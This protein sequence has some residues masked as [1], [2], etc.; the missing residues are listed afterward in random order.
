MFSAPEKQPSKH[1]NSPVIHHNFTTKNHPETTRFLKNP[2]KKR[3]SATR[4]KIPKNYFITLIGTP[5]GILISNWSFSMGWFKVSF[6]IV[7]ER[8]Y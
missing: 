3:H 6:R 4:E 1:H 7:M 8:L 5:S 2:L